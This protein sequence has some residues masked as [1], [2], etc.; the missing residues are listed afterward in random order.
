MDFRSMGALS[1]RDRTLPDLR[2]GNVASNACSVATLSA[3]SRFHG[4]AVLVSDIGVE[5]DSLKGIDETQ[6]P[7]NRP[8]FP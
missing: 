7:G 6:K 4:L 5:R 3:S 8:S 2:I 1:L